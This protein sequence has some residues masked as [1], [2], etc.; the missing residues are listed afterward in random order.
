MPVLLAFGSACAPTLAPRT[1]LAYQH[2]EPTP[3]PHH[4]EMA[5]PQGGLQFAMHLTLPHV[6]FDRNISYNLNNNT[7]NILYSLLH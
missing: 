7:R 3:A 6:P 5:Y 1:L 2:I 4:T